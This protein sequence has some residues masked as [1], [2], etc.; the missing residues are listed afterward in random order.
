MILFH[1]NGGVKIMSNEKDI[2]EELKERFKLLVQ[3]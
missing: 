3:G 2:A 1:P